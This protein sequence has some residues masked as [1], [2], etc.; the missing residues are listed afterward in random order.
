VTSTPRITRDGRM[1]R[2]AV[3]A[4]V[5]VLAM[6]VALPLAGCKGGSQS[7]A[8]VRVPD[9]TGLDWAEAQV[10]LA[11]AKLKP[12]IDARQIPGKK[13]LTVMSQSPAA[14]TQVPEGSRVTLVVVSGGTTAT[15]NP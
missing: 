1:A 6:S 4:L 7:G 13:A 14:K 8:I 3:M 11:G 5:L 9:V 12:V 15:P 2:A 10:V